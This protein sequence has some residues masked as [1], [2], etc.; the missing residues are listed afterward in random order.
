MTARNDHHRVAGLNDFAIGKGS[1]IIVF[2]NSEGLV[3]V[4]CEIAQNIEGMAKAA[5]RNAVLRR[6]LFDEGGLDGVPGATRLPS[7]PSVVTL[8]HDP[9][10]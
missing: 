5:D 4:A 2:Q 7:R 9:S 1:C 6:E 10:I 8:P 3:A